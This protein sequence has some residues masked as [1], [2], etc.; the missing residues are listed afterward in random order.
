MKQR[1]LSR[2]WAFPQIQ[3]IPIGTCKMWKAIAMLRQMYVLFM[4]S[5]FHPL[6]V[7][8]CPVSYNSKKAT[9]V[10]SGSNIEQ[11]FAKKS[12]TNASLNL[13]DGI[14]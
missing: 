5:V 8:N 6:S 11:D 10:S 4:I 7:L 3:N 14:S 2:Q 13:I 9:P 12:K 1:I